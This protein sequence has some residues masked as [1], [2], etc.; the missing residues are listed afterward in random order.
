MLYVYNRN[1]KKSTYRANASGCFFNTTAEKLIPF[2]RN[3]QGWVWEENL[4]KL[5]N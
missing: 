3:C 2:D 5:L 1:E 4:S